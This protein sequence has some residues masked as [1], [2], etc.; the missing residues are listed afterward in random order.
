MSDFT[1]NGR[2]GRG[3][4]YGRADGGQ[5]GGS[6]HRG[7]NRVGNRSGGFHRGG[8]NRSGSFHRGGSGSFHRDGGF[9]SDGMRDDQ[10]RSFRRDDR[11]R[12]GQNQHRSFN[13]E[14]QHRSFNR[15]NSGNR[16]GSFH[17]NGFHSDQRGDRRRFSRD[18]SRSEGYFDRQKSS[19]PF[20]YN[21]GGSRNSHDSRN[22]SRGGFRGSRSGDRGSFRG[23]RG[24][25][26]RNDDRRS[27]NRDSNR[28]SRRDFH[29]D[30]HRDGEDQHRS[31]HRDTDSR[32]RFDDRRNPDHRSFDRR[33]ND[34]S[35]DKSATGY[36]RDDRRNDRNDRR[37][38]AQ[39][40]GYR[41]GDRF[42]QS[43]PREYESQNPYTDRRHGEPKMPKGLDWS[44]LSS[45]DKRRL[46][47]LS[48]EHAENIGLHMLAA[49]T[50]EESDPQL[51][52]AHAKW[53]AHQASRVDIARETLGLISYHQGD[54]KTAN[55]ELRTAYRM[56]GQSDYLPLIADCERG[57]GHPEKAIEIA[58]SD[59]A[60][61]LTGEAKAEMM[62]V[63]AGAYADQKQ[64]DQ[65]LKIVRTLEQVPGLSGGYQMRALQAEQNFLDE[66]GRIAESEK[67]DDKATQ[68]EDLYADKPEED[69]P[70]GDLHDTDLE[71]LSADDDS[72]L[73]SALGIGFDELAEE[74]DR[75]RWQERRD[76]WDA[77]YNGS[78]AESDEDN[79]DTD[80]SDTDESA[81]KES[82]DNSD[83]DSDS[84]NNADADSANNSADNADSSDSSD[85]ASEK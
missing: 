61:K 42:S 55:R 47:G 17:R 73:Q 1:N 12:D 44:M 62:I 19:D 32:S 84:D 60:K 30:F 78:D 81:D 72:N 31:F 13:R 79:S 76:A 3:H 71:H 43:R 7:G 82:S 83:N 23:S 27:F 36:R 15:S 38:G 24:S 49:Y 11:N 85:E 75:N 20:S 10:R 58:L 6:F 35:F 18:G 28:D 5:H 63:F 53:V 9:H 2:N 40:G 56:N 39:N 69:D 22:G 50:L 51:S 33:S 66:A 77:V 68:L 45:D 14:G 4:G 59:D 25:F 8:P 46:R 48:K 80:D 21:G 52:L 54:W 34:R 64:Y 16:S 70:A 57:L 26:H 65:A 37:G 29:R 74:E 41:V 67:L